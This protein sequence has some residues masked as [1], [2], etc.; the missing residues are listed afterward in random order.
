MTLEKAKAIA[1]RYR[2]AVVEYCPTANRAEVMVYT[3]AYSKQWYRWTGGW[4]GSTP[5]IPGCK[6]DFEHE[7]ANP[8][9]CWI[10]IRG[11]EVK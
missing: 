3:D 5:V 9:Y 4:Q 7:I 1:K 11:K 6:C 2:K 8:H 10:F